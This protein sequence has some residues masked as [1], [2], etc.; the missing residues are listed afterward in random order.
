MSIQPSPGTGLRLLAFVG[1]GL[2]AVS[3]ALIVRDMFH[4]LEDDHKLSHP[5]RISDYFDMI[6]G[7]GLGGL[8][9]IMCGILHMTGEQLVDEFVG[10]C[11]AVF[12]EQ[13]DITQRTVKLE[14]EMKRIVAKFSEGRAERK[15]FS[16]EDGCKTF[17]CAAPAH[18]ASHARLFRSYR[19]RTNAGTDCTIWEAGRA[20]TAVPGLFSPISIGSEYIGETFVSGEFGWNNPMEELIEEAAL[21]FKDRHISCIINIGSGHLGHI[22]LSNGLSGLFSRIALD[23][24]R[25]VERMER[26]FGEVPDIYRRVSVEQGMQKLD[27]HLINLHELVAHT[28]SYLQGSRVTRRIDSLLQDLALRPERI[29]VQM[30][31]GVVPSTAEAPYLNPCPPPTPYFTRRRTELQ[32]MKNHFYSASDACRV[33]VLYGIGAGGKTQIALKFIR[34]NQNRFSEIFFVDASSKLTLENSLKAIAGSSLDKPSVD[35]ALRLLRTRRDDWLLFLDNADDYQLDPRPYISWPH[36]NVIITTRNREVRIHAPKCSI[37]VDRLELEDAT[38]LLLGGVDVPKGLETYEIAVKIVNELGSLALAIN[39]ARAFLAK[40]MCALDEYLSIYTQNREKLLDDK[41]IQTTDDYAYTVYTTWAVSFDK[42]SPDAALL[43]QLLSYMHHESI[44]CRLFKDAWDTWQAA[45]R[46]EGA[47]PPSIATFVSSLFAFIRK[48]DEAVPQTVT[49]F[50]STFTAIDLTWDILRFRN[51]IGEILSF[52]LLEFNTLT[53]SVSLHPLVQQ[54]AQHH[55]RNHD[56]IVHAS[57]TLLSLASPTGEKSTK[58][59]IKLHYTFLPRIGNAYRDGGLYPASFAVRQRALSETQQRLGREHPQTLACMSKLA[60]SYTDLGQHQKS[61]KLN[62]EVLQLQKR[63]LGDEH[64]DTLMTMSNLVLSYQNLGQYQDAIKLS[65]EALELRKRVLG[66]DH[67]DTLDTM[68]SLAVSY[69]LFGQYQDALKLNGEVFDLMKKVLGDEHPDTLL[70]MG[71]LAQVH[72]KLGQYQDALKLNEEVLR[73]RKRVLGNNHPL[74][75]NAMTSLSVS[76]LNLGHYQKAFKLNEEALELMKIVLGQ[77]HSSTLTSMHNLAHMY[78]SV[79]QYQDALRP[80]EEVTELAKR[81][82]GYDHPLTLTSMDNLATIYLNLG[83]SQD[84]LKLTQHVLELR[85]QALGRGSSD[86]L[87][88]MIDLAR[89]HRSLGQPQDGLRLSE[90]AAELAKRVLGDDNPL[91]LMCMGD[92]A[93]AYTSVSQY[94]EALK[95]FQ[96]VL[97]L[98]IQTAGS[99]HPYTLTAMNNLAQV[100]THLGQH[101]YALT[102]LERVLELMKRNLGREHPDTL[103]IMSNVASSQLDVGQYVDALKL[104]EE[105][106]ELRKRCLG[107]EHPATLIS[108]SSLALNHLKLGRYQDALKLGEKTLELMKRIL[109]HNHPDTLVTMSNLAVIQSNLGQYQ[110]ALK[111]DGEVL[112]LRKHALGTFHSDTLTSMSNVAFSTMKIG[113]HEAALKLNEEVLQLRQQVL[114]NDHPETLASMSNR[115]HCRLSLARYQDALKLNEEVVVLRK[116]AL[117]HNHPETLMSVSDLAH[118]QSELGQH[119]EALTLSMDVLDLRKLIL[120]LEHPAT[121]DSAK[122]VDKLKELLGYNEVTVTTRF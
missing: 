55:S 83:H 9:A 70:S 44:P 1:G 52:S 39:H 14:E 33:C 102:L 73:S 120:G 50:L 107:N 7:S 63:V 3:Q 67:P 42:L 4:R 29:R 11:K 78:A 100:H 69:S 21:I 82:L 97:Q 32:T 40:G 99:E 111:L 35:D 53:H 22:A 91:T 109:G 36:G 89:I 18:N 34:Q 31:S 105:V 74:T 46:K 95:L 71:N 12:L 60:Y 118:C 86:A 54:W 38:E 68:N 108:M 77:E 15:M 116:R 62:E 76:Q 8:L 85:K 56:E 87:S 75:L 98:R 90:E 41:S 6:C 92:L 96:E 20:T 16:Q 23:C 115:A 117:G 114:G 24:E 72:A 2:R 26:R 37:W 27:V 81:V 113:Q 88:T 64:L 49:T 19:S 66:N 112:E 48:E 122:Q 103:I 104:N 30:I 93:I 106:L 5:A 101:Q 79:G 58:T 51:L 80:S 47:P 65:E 121:V 94:Q 10:L 119:G 59:G 43:F 61:L 28:Q 17:V 13:L 25:V 45:E 84:A 57:Q 110:E